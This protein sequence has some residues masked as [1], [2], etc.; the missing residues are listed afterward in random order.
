MVMNDESSPQCALCSVKDPACR[1]ENGTGPESCP[2]KNYRE[3][4][5]KAL[6]EYDK[7]EIRE[8]A[9]MASIQEAECYINRHIKPYV[10]HPVKPRVQEICEFANK[11][12]Y[13][14]LGIAF[15]AGLHSEARTLTN[16]LKAQGFQVVSVVC[17]TGCTPKESLGLKDEQKIRI[18]EFESMCSPIVQA[19]ILNEERTDFNILVGLCV[20]HDS[21]FFKY[22]EAFT[23]VL[24]SKDRVLAH[25]PAAA[26]YTSG[27]YYAR[28]LRPGI[29]T[30]QDKECT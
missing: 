4:I 28:L 14:K 18:G 26:L 19:A 3:T 25:N 2:T 23:T 15:C 5:E 9:K 11:M 21:L 6:K 10:L 1:V 16:I 7:L 22:S 24:I 29:D 17:K 13:N 20:G 12:R 27:S 30:P 8:F